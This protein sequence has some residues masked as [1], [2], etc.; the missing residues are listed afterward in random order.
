MLRKSPS[1]G[2]CALTEPRLRRSE[3]ARGKEARF[4]MAHTALCSGLDRE[5]HRR[6]PLQIRPDKAP[7]VSYPGRHCPLL[8]LDKNERIS[9]CVRALAA[10]R[11]RNVDRIR[12]TL[13]ILI[14]PLLRRPRLE[15]DRVPLQKN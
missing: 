4:I 3:L 11:L 6:V 1:I 2:S 7:N 13:K 15:S 12:R 14:E 9:V 8:C 10:H 5:A